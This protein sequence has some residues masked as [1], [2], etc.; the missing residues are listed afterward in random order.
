MKFRTWEDTITPTVSIFHSTCL[1]THIY[2]YTYTHESIDTRVNSQLTCVRRKTWFL[3][4]DYLFKRHY[5]FT[6]RMNIFLHWRLSSF[7]MFTLLRK[8]R[9][10]TLDNLPM[11]YPIISLPTLTI[12]CG[13]SLITFIKLIFLSY[14]PCV[15]SILYSFPHVMTLFLT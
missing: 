5:C 12:L 2:T 7:V 14:P 9:S 8:P 13:L 10:K 1:K 4:S 11:N 15:C 3:C 6:R